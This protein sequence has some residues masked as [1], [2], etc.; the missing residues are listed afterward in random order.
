MGIIFKSSREIAKMREAGRVVHA[1]RDA[2]E[3]ACVPGATTWDLN[4]IAQEILAR[5]GTRS[6]FLGYGPQSA[7]RPSQQI[8]CLIFPRNLREW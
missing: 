6:A 3:A 7:V 8:A 4:A 1:V 5:T 2:V